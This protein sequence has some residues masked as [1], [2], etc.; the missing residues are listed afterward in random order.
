[1]FPVAPYPIENVQLDKVDYLPT[2]TTKGR[3]RL[4]SSRQ[5]SILYEKCN[6]CLSLVKNRNCFQLFHSGNKF[7]LLPKD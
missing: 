1:M 7:L 6:C 2:F 4:C 5:I 3:C